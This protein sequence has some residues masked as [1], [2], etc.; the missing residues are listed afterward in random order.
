MNITHLVYFF[1]NGFFQRYAKYIGERLFDDLQ[2]VVD[3]IHLWGFSRPHNIDK[4]IQLD[5]KSVV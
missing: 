2:I 3:I 5:R 4:N 1:A